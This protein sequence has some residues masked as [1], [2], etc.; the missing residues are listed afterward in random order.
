MVL[1]L[2]NSLKAPIK[3]K[4]TLIEKSLL[5]PLTYHKLSVSHIY[6]P[7]L[8]D[9]GLQYTPINLFDTTST[10]YYSS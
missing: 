7:T 5:V 1:V 2:W 4:I 8:V 10:K 3:Y 6:Y 9:G